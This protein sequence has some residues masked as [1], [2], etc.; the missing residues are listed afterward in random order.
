MDAVHTIHLAIHFGVPHSCRSRKRSTRV[1]VAW[2]AVTAATRPLPRVRV[3]HG[4]SFD[5]FTGIVVL[6]CSVLVWAEHGCWRSGAVSQ[7]HV[8]SLRGW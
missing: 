3:L 1:P 5:H 4:H 8:H 2:H 7:E 6:A